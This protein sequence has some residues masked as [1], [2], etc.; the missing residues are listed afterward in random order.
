MGTERFMPLLCEGKVDS[1]FV[2]FGLYPFHKPL[3]LQ[4][5]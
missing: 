4:I 3:A 2:M 5:V 1:A